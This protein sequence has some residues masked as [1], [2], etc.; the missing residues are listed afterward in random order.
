MA[1]EY[2]IARNEKKEDWEKSKYVPKKGEFI[3]FY[4]DGQSR[5]KVGDGVTNVNDLG[6]LQIGELSFADDNE[7][8]HL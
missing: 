2:S 7:V 8:L 3:I 1:K 6:Y 4:Q 5:L